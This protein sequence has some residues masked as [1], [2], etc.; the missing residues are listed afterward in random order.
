MA[1]RYW[2]GGTGNWSDDT[3]HWSTSSGGTPG[4]GN[5]PTLSDNVFF[6]SSSGL[7]GATVTLDNFTEM[8]DITC[9]SGSTFLIDTLGYGL[10]VYGSVL[11]EPGLTISA[12]IDIT[13]SVSININQNSATL[14]SIISNN[15]NPSI[16]LLS[17]LSL[18]GALSL[19]DASIDFNDFNVTA[20]R[21]SIS[22]N[23]YS[24]NVHLGNG[25][26]NVTGDSSGFTEVW[27]IGEDVLNGRVVNL[28]CELS[29]LKISDTSANDKSILFGNKTYNKVLLSG[30]NNCQYVVNGVAT[31]SEFKL[32][33]KPH[34]IV[35]IDFFDSSNYSFVKSN[36]TVSSF[37]V[38]GSSGNLITMY[39]STGGV[40]QFTLTKTSG[41]V[42][43]DYLDL[44]NSNAT[45][46]ATWYAGS[47]S[48]NTANNTGWIFTGPPST[49]S[50]PEML[51]TGVGR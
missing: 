31:F 19:S 35:F 10:T 39:D 23:N 46:G 43:C 22:T 32:D 16:T 27:G 3:N 42:V 34:T 4:T 8:L 36:F 20:Q 2:V 40:E 38:S 29:T 18:S 45:G 48:V 15:S 7:S 5:L 51:M 14:S 49:G 25:L 21:I 26:I 41:T 44:S 47:H 24:I 1:N 17:D 37:L 30:G 28:F 12:I 6:N 50:P 13:S 9:N 11:L 33:T